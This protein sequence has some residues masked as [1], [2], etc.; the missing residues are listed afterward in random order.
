MLGV[1]DDTKRSCAGLWR[2][3]LASGMLLIAAPKVQALENPRAQTPIAQCELHVWP[4]P[5]LAWTR[6]RARDNLDTSFMSGGAIGDMLAT[7]GRK[8]IENETADVNTTGATA[9]GPMSS[10]I[11]LQYL[12]EANLP[13]LLGLN[14]YRIVVH[15][16]P[17][18]SRTLR[19]VEGRY[20]T[21][22]SA[23][24]YAELILS[25]VVYSRE[26]AHGQNLKSFLR[27]RQFTD[28]T[29]PVRRFASWVQSDLPHDREKADVSNTELD[30][31]LATGLI[32]NLQKFAAFLSKH[33]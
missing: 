24:C 15:E 28:L 2:K 1:P 31:E 20:D 13:S 33:H 11:Q 16:T 25:D 18:T 10:A 29:G 32:A 17:L 3:T 9:G 5:G 23:P 4:S 8:R 19:N 30:A 22:N 14:G 6:Q 21:G 7:S 26:Y 12:T 27:F